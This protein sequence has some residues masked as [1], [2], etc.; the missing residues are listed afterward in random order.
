MVQFKNT[1]INPLIA[2]MEIEA[3]S[4]SDNLRGC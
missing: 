3:L 2:W 1:L 4:R